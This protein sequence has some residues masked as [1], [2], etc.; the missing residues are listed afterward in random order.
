M[1][2][3][4]TIG[5]DLAKNVFQVHGVDASGAS[6][7]RR[8]LRRSQVL[9]FFRK[10]QPCLIGIEACATSHYWAREIMVLG[11]G[12]K[13]MPPRY[14]KPYVK[15][16]KNDA[17]DAEAI[18]EAV[19][20]PT[21]RFVAVKSAE[22]QSVLM[23]HRTRELLVRQR[24]MLVNAL[25]AHMAEFG[26]V[27]RVGL[28][29]VKKLL[30]VLADD[31]DVRVPAPARDHPGHRAA[32]GERVD[33]DGHR[34]GGVQVGPHDG[35]VDRADAETELDRGQATPGP[36]YQAGRFVPALAAGRRR[37]VGDPA[38]QD[39]RHRRSLARR[40]DRPQADQGRRRG[41]GQQERPHRLGVVETWRDLSQ[42]GLGRSL[43]RPSKGIQEFGG[44][45]VR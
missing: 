18:C 30:A 7:I 38:S 11:H 44:V 26:V 25:R 36:D 14:V 23:V 17:A 40:A 42:T 4:T 20:R 9:P 35:G 3:V 2:E 8:Q 28:P 45:T 43:R 21:M 33:G 29:Q 31:D 41:A 22:R 13:L 32:G 15:R 39:T 27:A 10:Q 16:N 6:V 1:D 12:V 19:T 34:S 5:I 24:T 37:H